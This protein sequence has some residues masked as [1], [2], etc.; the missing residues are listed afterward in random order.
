MQFNIHGFLTSQM[1][2]TYLEYCGSVEL[3]RI[4][5]FLKTIM[6]ISFGQLV[7]DN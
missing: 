4:Q 1:F 7:T 6:T 2:S 5:T 3:S